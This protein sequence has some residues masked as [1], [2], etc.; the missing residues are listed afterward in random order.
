MMVAGR[1]D[2]R[3]RE[4]HV[5]RFGER[6]AILSGIE[7]ACHRA[8]PQRTST[9]VDFGGRSGAFVPSFLFRSGNSGCNGKWEHV[10]RE[11]NPIGLSRRHPRRSA[12]GSIALLLRG[13][14]PKDGR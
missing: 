13:I 3:H 7:L 1:A 4:A 10:E 14:C 8:D 11:T 2:G 5:D 9:D 12:S 6:V